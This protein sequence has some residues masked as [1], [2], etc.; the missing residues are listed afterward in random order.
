MTVE[1]GSRDPG[2]DVSDARPQATSRIADL[3]VLDLDRTGTQR[4]R[5][6]RNGAH[7]VHLDATQQQIP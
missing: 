1:A 4:M 3:Q 7:A 5:R 6:I 2:S